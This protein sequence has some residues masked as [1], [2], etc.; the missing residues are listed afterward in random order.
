VASTPK[1][2][3]ASVGTLSVFSASMSSELLPAELTITVPCDRTEL[4]TWL[5]VRSSAIR[6]GYTRV[7]E[8]V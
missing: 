2:P 4:A 6:P 7:S 8:T 1:T 3:S 5:M